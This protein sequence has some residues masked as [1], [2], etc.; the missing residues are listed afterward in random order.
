MFSSKLK[1]NNIPDDIVAEMNRAIGDVIKN[2]PKFFDMQNSKV[3]IRDNLKNIV[4]CF[5]EGHVKSYV[6]EDESRA[7]HFE[8]EGYEAPSH[9]FD[10]R[11]FQVQ[12]PHCKNCNGEI[13]F[14]LIENLNGTG[15]DWIQW[16]CKNK[17]GYYYNVQLI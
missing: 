12:E 4:G 13:E 3:N 6:K 2:D 1:P 15:I 7:L 16:Y 5:N 11:V 14:T 9:P 8:Y 17:C 10:S